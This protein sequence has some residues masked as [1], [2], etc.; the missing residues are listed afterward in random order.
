MNEVSKP[1]WADH[2]LGLG[3]LRLV[4]NEKKIS[5]SWGLWMCIIGSDPKE[6]ARNSVTFRH[7][8]PSFIELILYAIGCELC[9]LAWK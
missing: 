6:D 2:L 1:S 7:H 3:L 5:P 4:L 8:S 9:L